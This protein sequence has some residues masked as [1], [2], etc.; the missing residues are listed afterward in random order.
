MNHAAVIPPAVIPPAATN[1]ALDLGAALAALVSAAAPAPGIDSNALAALESRIKA[2]EDR[3]PVKTLVV[4][5]KEGRETAKFEGAQHHQ[6][7]LLIQMASARDGKGYRVPVWIAGPTGSGKT[8]AAE[9]VAVALGLEFGSHG[10]MEQAFELMGFVD[11]GGTYHATPFVRL[12]E[13]GGVCLLDEIDSWS[14][15]ASL[16]LNG[17]LANG[18]FTL[19]DGRRVKRHP[20]FVCLG[21]ANTFGNGAT[22]EFVGRNKL[23]RAFLSRFPG[24]LSWEYDETLESTLS[25]N[26]QWARR[27]QKA[28]AR[29]AAKGL[30]VIIDPRK[31]YA[32]AAY[33]AGGM[34]P[35]DAARLTYLAGLPDGQVNMIEGR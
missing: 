20:D 33:I 19:P 17:A 16:A 3:A 23:D 18:A 11:A 35:D 7:A 6:L 8:H 30:K 10:A 24:V 15:S 32:G 14:P 34:T 5:D 9:Q 2:V 31:T 13:S 1:A 29:A 4:I 28:R 22:A 12:Y 25:G 27:V 26:P 21:A